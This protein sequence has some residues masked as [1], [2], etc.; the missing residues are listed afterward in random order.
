MS[1]N[2]EAT[3]IYELETLGVL[4]GMALLRAFIRL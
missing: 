2:D 4:I 1:A 3:I